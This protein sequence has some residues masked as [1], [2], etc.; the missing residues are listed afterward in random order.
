M[1]GPNV[2]LAPKSPESKWNIALIVIT[3]LSFV[4]RYYKI[5][6]PDQVV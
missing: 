3:I 5:D 6:E 4:T 1:R 2:L